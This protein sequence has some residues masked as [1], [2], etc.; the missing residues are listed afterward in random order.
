MDLKYDFNSIA[1]IEDKA[2]KTIGAIF[3]SGNVGF[4]TM[5]LLVWGGMLASRPRITLQQAG[6]LI[7]EYVAEGGTLAGLDEIIT[8]KMV[9]SGLFE[10]FTQAES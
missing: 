8:N 10:N 5:R 6:E 1:E 3:T 4:N 9:E 2:G 7:G